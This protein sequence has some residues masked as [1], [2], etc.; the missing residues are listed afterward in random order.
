MTA[1]KILLGILLA[2]WLLG[3]IRVGGEG[4][5]GEEGLFIKVKAGPFKIHVYPV[6]KKDK[7]SKE[8]REKESKKKEEAAGEG[9]KLSKGGALTMVKAGLP[10]IGEAAGDLR[11]KIRIDELRLDLLLG[12]R[13]A[14]A[15]AL[16]FGFSNAVIGMILPVFE[17]NFN[18]KE[19]RI[20]TGMDFNAGST[21]VW[22]K[23]A[24][25]ARIGQLLSF[26]LRIGWKFFRNYQA[27]KKAG[28]AKKE[29]S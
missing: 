12:G 5:Y 14:A 25:S 20:R 9:E 28:T 2:L 21:T 8:K 15:T 10:L 22:V 26:A 18:V 4:E 16:A 17:Q 29:A 6:K 13:D 19:R 3:R 1:L 23:A 11:E 24:F 7:P 27:Q